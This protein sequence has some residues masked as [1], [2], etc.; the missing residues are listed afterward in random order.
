MRLADIGN[1]NRTFASLGMI[2]DTGM[3]PVGTV[4]RHVGKLIEAGW[5]DT[6]GRELLR[7]DRVSQAT[8]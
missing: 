2:A 3:L 4:K 8:D 1:S 5:L 7:G 6:R